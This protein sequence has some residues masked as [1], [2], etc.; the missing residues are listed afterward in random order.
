MLEL[1]LMSVLRTNV[2]QITVE[3]LFPVLPLE[4]LLT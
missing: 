2:G 3:P 4:N 1:F